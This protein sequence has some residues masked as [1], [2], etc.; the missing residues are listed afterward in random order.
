MSNKSKVVFIGENSESSFVG[1]L[2]TELPIGVGFETRQKGR[3]W[4]AF[5]I[6]KNGDGNAAVDFKPVKE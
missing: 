6:G 3:L 1:E 4:Q 5:K 2:F